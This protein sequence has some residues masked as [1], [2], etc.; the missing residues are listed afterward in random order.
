MT[1]TET[2]TYAA[3][4]VEVRADIVDLHQRIWR[5][6]AQ[7]GLWWTGAER[8]AI[9]GEARNARNC[10]LCA[11]RK[12]ALSPYAIDGTHVAESALPAPAIEAVHRIATD[13]GR[14]SEAWFRAT[15]AGGVSDAAYV[16]LVVV[17]ACVV[18]VDTFA[19]ARLR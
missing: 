3:A 7:P 16:E 17:I 14:L 11:E 10:A 19:H 4:P 8:V 2:V 9:A 18:A 1:Q 5:W 15:L 13:P 6:L 12:A